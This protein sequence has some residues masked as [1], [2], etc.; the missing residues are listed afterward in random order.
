MYP[1]NQAKTQPPQGGVAPPSSEPAQEP[2]GGAG[3]SPIELV[4]RVE[5]RQAYQRLASKV[6]LHDTI[7]EIDIQFVRRIL[8]RYQIPHRT[9]ATPDGAQISGVGDLQLGAVAIIASDATRLVGLVGGVVLDTASQPQLG[10]GK[11]QVYYG[12]GGAYKPRRWL[13]TYAIAQQQLSVGGKADRP[14]INQVAVDLGSILFGR[15]FNW[16]KLDLLPT[17]DF[18]G[19][20]GT[21]LFGTAEVGSLVIGRVGLFVRA[22]T[23]L[24][25]SDLLDYS[26]AG[27]VRYLFQLE[28][29]KTPL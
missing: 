6:A 9:A 18:A 10:T 2:E 19:A 27:G 25:G 12:V 8:L 21:R 1:A 3:V 20:E 24:L 5:L 26:L 29:G 11:Q 4:P 28:R 15:Q 14:D 23:Q 17:L 13:L 16:L 22:G 7:L